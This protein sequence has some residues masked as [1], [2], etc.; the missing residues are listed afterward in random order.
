MMKK[1]RKQQVILIKYAIVV[2]V[3]KRNILLVVGKKKIKV[4]IRK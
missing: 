2:G 1:R 4:L 3:D